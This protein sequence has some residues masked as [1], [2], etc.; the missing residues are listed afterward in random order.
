MLEHDAELRFWWRHRINGFLVLVG[1]IFGDRKGRWPDGRIIHTSVLLS[2]DPREGAVVNTANSS[3]LLVGPESVDAA[4][5]MP[6]SDTIGWDAVLG[7]AHR[8]QINKRLSRSLRRQIE[9]G[10][11]AE[12]DKTVH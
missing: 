5:L 2:A 3:Y 8:I 12:P 9:S 10:D 11:P 7:P 4:E 1:A 6:A